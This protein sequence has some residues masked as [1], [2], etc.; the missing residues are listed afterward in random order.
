MVA[1]PYSV[2]VKQ[3]FVGVDHCVAPQDLLANEFMD[4]L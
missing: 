3:V 2:F 4:S 1:R